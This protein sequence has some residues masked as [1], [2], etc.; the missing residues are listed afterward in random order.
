MNLVNRVYPSISLHT[1][2]TGRWSITGPP[3]QQLPSDLFDIVVPD[4]GTVWLGHD[5]DAV[6]LRIK[7]AIANDKPL[8]DLFARGDDPHTFNC[9]DIFQ[10][11]YPPV[12]ANAYDMS[13]PENAEWR[14]KL[15]WEG[16]DD[17]R[18]VFS[19]R[20]V[21]RLIY[22]GNA[23]FAGDIPGARQLGLDGPKLVKASTN[24]LLKH[25]AIPQYWARIDDQV[26]RLGYSATWAG[27]KRRLLGRGNGVY[28]EAANHPMQGGVADLMNLT[29]IELADLCPWL[30]F[31]LNIHDELWMECPVEREAETWPI[32]QRVV[33]Q[34]R[35][36]E[37][38]T[39]PFPASFKR[40]DDKGVIEKV[41]AIV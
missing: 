1:Q 14:T 18:R 29:I 21:Y 27:R 2:A 5:L 13:I 25:P 37:G 4:A 35:N 38:V 30:V 11:A 8:L 23:R 17:V 41:K 24:W 33:Q 15:G 26:R 31:V 6:E 10:F 32:Y 19:K 22:R 7:A 34:A 40:Y 39:V 3:L 28:R 20:F 36:I 12:G 9:C 16:K